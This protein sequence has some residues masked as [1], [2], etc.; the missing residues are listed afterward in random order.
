M[1][2]Q[3]QLRSYIYN[4]LRAGLNPDEV[5]A[6]LRGAG[7]TE[8]HIQAGFAAV[9]SQIAP[10][11]PSP[12]LEQ[13][14]PATNS[15]QP[16][17]TY[18]QP[19]QPAVFQANGKK[20]GRIKTAWLLMKQSLK[21]LKNNKQLLK[22]PLMG[23]IMSLLVTIIFGLL[24]YL[25]R[26]SMIYTAKDVFGEDEFYLKGPGYILG[27]LY[28]VI[29]FFV[30][31]IYNA[32][33][34][35]HVLDIFRGKSGEYKSY[36]KIAWS[37]KG[38][39][40]IYSLIT[41]TVGLILHAIEQRARWLGWIVSRILGTLWSLA[42]LFTI[43]IIVET[44]SSTPSAIKQSTK[45]FISRWGENIIAR[46][47]FGGL[48]FLMYLLIWLPLMFI[49]GMI[50]FPLELVGFALWFA[51]LIISLIFF[52]TLETAASNILSTSLYYYARYG[53]VP[54]AFDPELLNSV[55]VPKKKKR[56]LFGKKN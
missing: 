5:T 48:M 15:S 33:L 1:D 42:N 13:S 21:V 40:F 39:I 54:A 16:D 2:H 8:E 28:Y 37:K 51:L 56:G 53:Q 35:A 30:V 10:S 25:A 24:F 38:T 55:F 50:L 45:L 22:Y 12:T 34:A 17:N 23:V 44:D 36:M 11:P 49:F 6:Q 26:D 20:R 14:T 47:T 41:A 27:F 46:I 7:W 29:A 43:P 32:G 52:I 9:S 19:N 3:E 31:Y 18:A 4:Q